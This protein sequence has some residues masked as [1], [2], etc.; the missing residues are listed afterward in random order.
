MLTTIE[1]SDRLF[2]LSAE[3]LPPDQ[4]RELRRT[5]RSLNVAAEI[6]MLRDGDPVA[7]ALLQSSDWPLVRHNATTWQQALA[8]SY[9]AELTA[10][11]LDAFVYRSRLPM[12]PERF[13]RFLSRRFD[14][15]IRAAGH[16][17]LASR[18][19]AVGLWSRAGALSLAYPV[20]AWWASVPAKR[21]PKGQ[22]AEEIK[23]RW[24]EPYGDRRQEF[25]F[26]GKRIDATEL[27]LA[28]REC[29]LSASEVELGPAEWQRFADPFPAWASPTAQH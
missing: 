19:N 23:R 21:W 1:C 29:E 6:V 3:A 9:L 14:R 2:V 5:L 22:P 24:E 18:P 17:W 20:G 10:L 28:L 7:S 4:L 11:G 16:F 26:L 12:H 8:G 27:R 25:V 13:A 15:L